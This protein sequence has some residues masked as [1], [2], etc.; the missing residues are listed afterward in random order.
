MSRSILCIL[1]LSYPTLSPVGWFL[2]TIHY[3]IHVSYRTADDCGQWLAEQFTQSIEFQFQLIY[4]AN[5][6]HLSFWIDLRSNLHEFHSSQHFWLKENFAHCLIRY[7]F[8]IV[9]LILH[10]QNNYKIKL[11]KIDTGYRIFKCKWPIETHIFDQKEQSTLKKLLFQ[12][13]FA[14][15]W[16][17]NECIST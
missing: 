8:A 9:F 16:N 4:T 1:P 10:F 11:S 15:L 12:L 6:S 13:K 14:W 17:L 2:N 7:F 5:L 3:N